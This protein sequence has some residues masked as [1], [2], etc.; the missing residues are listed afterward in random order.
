MSPG[1]RLI[2]VEAVVPSDSA[3]PS[4]VRY[5]DLQMMALTGGMQRTLEEFEALFT[6]TGF[7]GA[8]TLYFGSNTIVE[9]TAV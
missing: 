7:R 3:A 5:G 6:A 2:V 9:A 4:G 1:A 8:R